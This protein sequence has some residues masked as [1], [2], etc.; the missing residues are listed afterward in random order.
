[1]T[2]L[3]DESFDLR[4][5]AVTAQPLDLPAETAIPASRAEIVEYQDTRV[6]INASAVQ[7]G[8]LVLGDQFYPG[9]QA[10]VDGRP[11]IVY[12]VNDVMR[13]VVLPPGD[14]VVVFQ[15]EPRSLQIG[16]GLSLAGILLLMILA[17]LDG[18]PRVAGRLR[19]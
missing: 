2:R 14:R 19:R 3:L 7:R 17:V 18:H 8:L 11:A 15:F 16:G 6:V 10:H 12:R 5:A 1:M 9:W 4:N 13:G